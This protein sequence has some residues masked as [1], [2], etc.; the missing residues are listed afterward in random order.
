MIYFAYQSLLYTTLL[1]WVFF[2]LKKRSHLSFQIGW[3]LSLI[4]MVGGFAGAR[5]FHVFY[6]APDHY[7]EAPLKI[8]SFWEG[9]F[10]FFGG[11]LVA[12]PLASFYLHQ[13]KQVF[14]DWADF[15]APVVAM[16]YALG[17]L[18]CLMAGCCYGHFCDLPWAI[19]SRHPTQI[20]AFLWELGVFFIIMSISRREPRPRTGDIFYLW[21]MGHSLG[22]ILMEQFRGDFRG[23]FWF[24]LSISSWFSFA[25]FL[26]ALAWWV[27]HHNR[28]NT[29]P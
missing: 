17:R 9:G 5:L 12:I 28:P 6:E 8:L 18:G 21:L 16:G 1:V 23:G 10:V 7:L 27:H 19:S 11:W 13:Q 22:R 3:N 20:Y 26:W 29:S 2:R 25:L 14:L 4:L 15:F 24:G